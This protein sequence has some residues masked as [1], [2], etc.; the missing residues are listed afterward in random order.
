[1]SFLHAFAATPPLTAT[2]PDAS[3][4]PPLRHDIFAALIIDSA[5]HPLLPL[6]HVSPAPYAYAYFSLPAGSR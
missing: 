4:L 5:C 2:P 1:L 6:L 3:P